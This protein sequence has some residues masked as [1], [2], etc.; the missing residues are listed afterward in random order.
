MASLYSLRVHTSD[1]AKNLLMKMVENNE[2]ANR[3]RDRTKTDCGVYTEIM[4]EKQDRYQRHSARGFEADFVPQSIVDI[5]H[6]YPETFYLERID[7]KK[8]RFYTKFES[9]VIDK[10]EKEEEI[11]I[12]QQRAASSSPVLVMK[13]EEVQENIAR[14]KSDD[15]EESKYGHFIG[16]AVLIG[17]Q[18]VLDK[19]QD[20]GLSKKGAIQIDKVLTKTH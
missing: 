14:F 17:A 7:A 20:H 13:E 3:L 5:D 8:R 15:T 1:S 11:E 4:N 10:D 6:F 2:I 9:V 19:A 16:D 12:K 18:K